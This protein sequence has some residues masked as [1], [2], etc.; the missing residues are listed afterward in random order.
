M[1]FIKNLSVYQ[2]LRLPLDNDTNNIINNNILIKVYK[3]MQILDY[4]SFIIKNQEDDLIVRI[5]YFNFS[6]SLL[7]HKTEL[8]AKSCNINIFS[9]NKELFSSERIS[10][11]SLNYKNSNEQTYI[12]RFT[13]FHK[14][15]KSLNDDELKTYKLS[16][17]IYDY[18]ILKNEQEDLI[19]DKKFNKS[20]EFK[21]F[22]NL[23]NFKSSEISIL[24][25]ILS[26]ILHI[27]N[28]TL[29][30][31]NT[32]SEH[33]LEDIKELLHCR[34]INDIKKILLNN[35]KLTSYLD[36][37]SKFNEKE[38]KVLFDYL[39]DNQFNQEEFMNNQIIL[40]ESLYER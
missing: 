10:R 12:S 32:I 29:D 27:S 17:N 13:I 3:A 11:K 37:D 15:L 2:M 18:K 34:E 21:D 38:K 23:F 26:L 7:Y 35:L 5:P 40:M 31:N 6:I 1:Y 33:K 39:P 9:F 28:L 19:F 8:I 24:I 14:M 25:K 4:F 36:F 16:R 30:F 22:L 20:T